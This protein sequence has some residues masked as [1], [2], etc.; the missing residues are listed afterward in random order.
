MLCALLQSGANCCSSCLWC[1][2]EFKPSFNR[3]WLLLGCTS[4]E[5]SLGLLMESLVFS[6]L[7]TALILTVE[8]QI[9][10]AVLFFSDFDSNS[11]SYWSHLCGCLPGVC[12]SLLPIPF[13]KSAYTVETIFCF[14]RSFVYAFLIIPWKFKVQETY[15]VV[16]GA[17]S[18]HGVL[19]W[20]SDFLVTERL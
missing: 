8:E 20:T 2:Q 12:S 15:V 9:L 14:G 19:P 6:S 11:F 3:R 10:D 18:F 7:I 4:W 5:N 17:D 13:M 16:D 1:K